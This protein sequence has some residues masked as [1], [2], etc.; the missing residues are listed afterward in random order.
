MLS[1]NIWN[2]K[3]NITT[4]DQIKY[5]LDA[6]H[7]KSEQAIKNLFYRLRLK[8]GKNMIINNKALGYSLLCT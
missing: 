7:N 2:N 5:T 4:V 1:F 3:T 8:I 6:E